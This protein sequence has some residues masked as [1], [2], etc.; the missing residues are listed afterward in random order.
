MSRILL[1]SRIAAFEENARLNAVFWK[2]SHG[3]VSSTL[4]CPKRQVSHHC[5]A[6]RVKERQSRAHRHLALDDP[7]P[8]DA[9]GSLWQ[10]GER[11]ETQFPCEEGGRTAVVDDVGDSC[12]GTDDDGSS[13]LGDLRGVSI[14]NHLVEDN[15][16]RSLRLRVTVRSRSEYA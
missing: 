5:L 16:D 8:L 10:F 4:F 2:L 3:P 1:P 12:V 7:V 14:N 15:Q 11:V 13:H 9:Y 6:V